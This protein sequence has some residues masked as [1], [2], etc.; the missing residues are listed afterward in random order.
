MIDKKPLPADVNQ[1]MFHQLRESN[2]TFE[3][4]GT[5]KDRLAQCNAM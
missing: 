2:R 1:M 3:L 5:Q 4:E